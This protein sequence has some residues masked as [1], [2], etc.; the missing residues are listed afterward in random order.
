MA[1]VLDDPSDS[2]NQLYSSPG[3][4]ALPEGTIHVASLSLRMYWMDIESSAFYQ[5]IPVIFI[6]AALQNLLP[7]SK[8][9]KPPTKTF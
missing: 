7:H 9:V 2:Q 1:V 4:T 8:P 6:P 3:D 5:T